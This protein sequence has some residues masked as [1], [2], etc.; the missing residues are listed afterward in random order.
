VK[1]CRIGRAGGWLVEPGDARAMAAA[2][3]E[4]CTLEEA[5]WQELS[6]RARSSVEGYTWSD[7]CAMFEQRFAALCR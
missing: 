6:R 4:A 2:I 5:S 7:T 3:V 1:A